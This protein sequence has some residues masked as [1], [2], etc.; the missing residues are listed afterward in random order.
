MQAFTMLRNWVE[1]GNVPSKS[2]AATRRNLSDTMPICSYPEYAK[3][4]SGMR[5]R[6][7]PIAA[8]AINKQILCSHSNG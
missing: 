8:L 1:S 4:V 3:Y 5:A 6:Q 2:V 7:A